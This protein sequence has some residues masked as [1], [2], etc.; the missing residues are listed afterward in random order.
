MDIAMKPIYL[1]LA[2][3]I[4]STAN[5]GQ[6]YSGDSIQKLYMEMQYLYQAGIGIHQQFPTTTDRA[7]LKAC[8]SEYGY[9]GTRAKATVGIANRLE[10]SAKEAL[11]DAAWRALNCAKCSSPMSSCDPLPDDLKNIKNIM[12]EDYRKQNLEQ[13]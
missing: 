12:A 1:V 3:L 4:G 7:E 11:I 6:Q 5:A 13:E 10:H 9:I 8:T 2:L